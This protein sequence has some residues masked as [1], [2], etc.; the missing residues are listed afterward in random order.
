MFKNQY[1]S[2]PIIFSPD[3][4]LLQLSFAK[5]ASDRGEISLSIKSRN[6]IVLFGSLKSDLVQPEKNDFTPILP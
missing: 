6:H 2:N 5:K 4:Q 3:G 1:S